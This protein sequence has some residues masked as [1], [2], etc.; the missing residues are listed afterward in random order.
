M[1]LGALIV[2]VRAVHQRRLSA[3]EYQQ[4]TERQALGLEQMVRHER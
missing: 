3:P 1:F 4:L 2:H